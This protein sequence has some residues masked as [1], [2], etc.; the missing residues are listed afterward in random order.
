MKCDVLIGVQIEWIGIVGDWLLVHAG[1]IS[2]IAGVATA[3]VAIWALSITARDSR[4]RS[5]PVLIPRLRRDHHSVYIELEIA[6]LGSSAARDVEVAFPS[7]FAEGEPSG[8]NLHA[9]L[10]AKYARRLPVW[11]PGEKHIN[12]YR[13]WGNPDP[14]ES[15]PHDQVEVRISY[16]GNRLRRYKD[17]FTLDVVPLKF[18]LSRRSD[19]DVEQR[20]KAIAS[21]VQGVKG[22][23]DRASRS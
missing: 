23:I 17:T 5:R 12:T 14:G 16:K 21:A 9:F 3:V 2:V 10:A 18:D 4:E 8:Q 22:S 15:V 7:D 13:V 1:A 11:G 6:N 19:H 20:L